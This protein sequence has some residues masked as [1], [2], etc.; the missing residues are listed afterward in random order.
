MASPE[1]RGSPRAKKSNLAWPLRQ[2]FVSRKARAIYCPIG[3]NGCTFLKRQMVLSSDV[4]YRQQIA[5]F[6]VHT[7]TD[8]ARTGMQLSDY[9]D[10]EVTELLASPDYFRFAVIRA[11]I[12]RLI[13]AYMEKFV[14]GRMSPPN[15]AHTKPV[16]WHVQKAAGLEAADMDRGITFRE[17]AEFVVARAPTQL[18]AHWRPQ[19]L[20]LEGVHWDRLYEMSELM[21]I[22]DMLEARSGRVLPRKAVNVT[23]NLGR[24]LVEG[25]A[26]LL[27]AEIAGLP[28]LSI[29]SYLDPGLREAIE[30]YYAADIALLDEKRRAQRNRAAQ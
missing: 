8:H 10:T 3:K 5:D 20:Y 21:E 17:F 22:S 6:N 14:L 29:D 24:T 4:E 13:S 27:P 28:P 2:N 30:D 16:V 23:G 12:D 18:D 1:F 19:H 9:S 7:L 25:G 15:W 11:P 26:D